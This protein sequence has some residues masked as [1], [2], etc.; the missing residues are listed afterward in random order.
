MSVYSENQERLKA[1]DFNLPKFGQIV[2][3]WLDERLP[4]AHTDSDLRKV[5]SHTVKET[6]EASDERSTLGQP[7]YQAVKEGMELGDCL[8]L[9]VAW[10]EANRQKLDLQEVRR[11]ING[12]GPTSVIYDAMTEAAGNIEE[13]S[14]VKDIE[15]FL[16]LVMSALASLPEYIQPKQIIEVVARKNWR[17]YPAEA[18][19][20]ILPD[21]HQSLNPEQLQLA[22]KHARRCLRFIRDFH[23][24]E[25]GH[26]DR[27]IN[28]LKREDF[29][30][31][32]PLILS[33]LNIDINVAEVEADQAYTRLQLELYQEYGM[34]DRAGVNL[35]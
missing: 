19:V 3:V 29:V 35:R 9:P 26:T 12:V 23:V 17:N 18:F 2:K 4:I 20:G 31:Y 16:G 33:Y 27:S 28:G 15:H 7:E 6:R 11:H 1:G 13:K 22:F 25:L 5:V 14:A 21:N 30:P 8:W 24:N 10:L 34:L 32:L